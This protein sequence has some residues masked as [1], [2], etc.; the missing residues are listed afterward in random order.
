MTCNL[1]V[2]RSVDKLRWRIQLVLKALVSCGAERKTF[3]TEVRLSEGS[4]RCSAIIRPIDDGHQL[5]KRPNDQTAAPHTLKCA[6]HWS[7]QA[8][9]ADKHAPL[10]LFPVFPPRDR[11]KRLCRWNL[12]FKKS[13]GRQMTRIMDHLNS[14]NWNLII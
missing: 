10:L 13:S 8:L 1:N 5:A 14:Q 6:P 3:N 7:Q 4:G 2:N 9:T 12:K 11:F